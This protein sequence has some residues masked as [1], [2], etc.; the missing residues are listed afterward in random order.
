VGKELINGGEEVV[1]GWYILMPV[2]PH[3]HAENDWC[4]G[5]Y[6]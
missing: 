1:M 5:V 2:H 4:R 3:A 6:N